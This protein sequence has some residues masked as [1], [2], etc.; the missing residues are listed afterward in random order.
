[1]SKLEQIRIVQK[2]FSFQLNTEDF[3]A[4]AKEIGM[5]R[6]EL[7]KAEFEFESAKAKFKAIEARCE[8]QISSEV[9]AIQNKREMR[10]V[11]CEQVH[12]FVRAIV[13]W[14]YNDTVL[15]DRAM[16]MAERQPSLI[17][18]AGT[19]QEKSEVAAFGIAK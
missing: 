3:A 8:A 16:E 18:D 13:Y 11:E 17:P 12:D 9:R 14:R 6:D 7:S 10:T 19:K 4:K 2:E 1:M 15:G 5:L